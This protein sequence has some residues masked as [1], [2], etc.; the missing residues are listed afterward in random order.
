MRKLI[1]ILAGV[2]TAL[3]AAAGLE[4]LTS[5][6]LMWRLEAKER[7]ISAGKAEPY[8]PVYIRYTDAG[9]PDML[10]AAGV[11]VDAVGHTVLTARVPL[12]LLDSVAGIEAISCIQGASEAHALLDT[13]RI[14]T[15]VTKIEEAADIAGI[16]T[17][18]TGKGVLVA[19]IDGGLD[20]TH[21]A[22]YTADRSEL[23]LKRVWVH[24]AT[25]GTPPEGFDYGAE[26]R[27]PD[28]ILAY[29]TDL[30]YYSHG[31][32]VM[33]IA[34]GGDLT[35]PY[36]GIASEATLA[37]SNF[38]D[39]DKGISDA[40]KYLFDT[41]ESLDM[42][43]V[44]NM[45]LGT[46]M[47]PHDGTSLRDVLGDELSGEGRILVGA[48]GNDGMVDMHLT[49]TFGDTETN[50]LAGLAFLENNPGA[51][52]LQIWGEP[53][54]TLKV[55]VCTINKATMQ[56]VYKSRTFDCSKTTTQTVTLQKP[57]DQSSG[58]FK[59]V[60]QISPLN[61]KP[62]AHITLNISDY[63]PDKV[64]AVSISGE[65]GSTFHA[66]CNNNYCC[67][68]KHLD[69]MA[70]PD[71]THGVC[72]IGGTG[73]SI[74]TVA[75]F[76]SRNFM[77]ALQGTPQYTTFT[78]GDISPFSNS[79][80]SA[81]GRMK[82]D[83]AAPGSLIASA[84]NST[85]PNDPAIVYFTE[86]NGKKYP[87]GVYQG[88]SMA[89]P[90]VA[91]VIALWLQA[92]PTLT[93]GQIRDVLDRTCRRDE[94]TGPDAGNTWGRGKIDAYS[95][96][97]YVL[98]NYAGVS[99]V[100]AAVGDTSW[101]ANIIDGELRVLYYR[102]IASTSIDIYTVSGTLVKSIRT[103]PHAMGDEEVVPL[104]RLDKGMYLI[105]VNGGGTTQAIKTAI[106]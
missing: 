12:S 22:F 47:G 66:W 96:L 17:P 95:G 39:V 31:S 1:L 75:S 43:A 55:N 13:A 30:A 60:T 6:A 79:G 99:T 11:K 33:N 5:E 58:Y 28:D 56:P 67:F 42:P 24:D 62:M 69:N 27:T 85:S 59:I 80:P 93:P 89:S 16:S 52:E 68:R 14:V 65:S 101:S 26:L 29:K 23:R 83:V 84:F 57:F 46:Q 50:V 48:A 88:T 51:G 72:E 4:K 2:S 73:K 36:H 53:G 25:S 45:S 90:H 35:S 87:Y 19:A 3:G 8:L 20:F 81:D 74:I 41:A 78:V 94:Y 70:D 71:A 92:A 49:K 63:K 91:G 7:I 82:P 18:F 76:N 10:R 9:I 103:A 15:G 32:H 98:R 38:T 64:L 100:D 44:I 54:K 106:R 102:D 40:I 61:G 104:G 97:V 77:P 86:W 21:P 34:A 105:S 37:F